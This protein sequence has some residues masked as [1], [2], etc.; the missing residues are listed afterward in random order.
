VVPESE[1]L[2]GLL[3]RA[4]PDLDTG[5]GVYAFTGNENVPTPAWMMSTV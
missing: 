2:D 3:A 4:R 5:C 1:W